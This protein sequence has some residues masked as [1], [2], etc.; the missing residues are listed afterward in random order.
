MRHKRQLGS[1]DKCGFYLKTTYETYN[2]RGFDRSPH[3]DPHI[4]RGIDGISQLGSINTSLSIRC[5]PS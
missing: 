2:P 1:I 3:I 4:I 5:I